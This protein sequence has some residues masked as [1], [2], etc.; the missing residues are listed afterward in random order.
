MSENHGLTTEQSRLLATYANGPRI[1]DAVAV[2][3]E[4]LKLESKGLLT[5]VG[6]G[7]Y[8]LTAAGRQVHTNGMSVEEIRVELNELADRHNNR[9]QRKAA[10]TW[11]TARE[12]E[13]E[14]FDEARTE[15]LTAELSERTA[16]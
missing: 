4:V 5:H 14:A 16:R 15:V 8:A 11:G 13:D 12:R 7:R 1:W 6:E 2:Y 10:F 3:E 9:E